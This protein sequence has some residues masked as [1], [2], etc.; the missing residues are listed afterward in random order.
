[1][2]IQNFKEKS[3]LW[4]LIAFM[5]AVRGVHRQG[6]VWEEKNDNNNNNMDISEYNKTF[7]ASEW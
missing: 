4:S 3:I 2:A 6:C 7:F 5:S 1:M